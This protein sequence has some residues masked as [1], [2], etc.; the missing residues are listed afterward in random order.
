MAAG[1][2]VHIPFCKRKCKYCDFTSGVGSEN[3]MRKYQRALIKEIQE[4]VFISSLAQQ[5]ADTLFFGGGTPSIY[6][7]EAM[8]ELMT[9]LKPLLQEGAEITMEANPG[10]LFTEHLHAYKAMGINRLSIGL[11]SASNQ[12]LELLGRIHDW[13]TFRESYDMARTAGFDNINIDLISAV[14]GQTLASFSDTMKK[15]VALQPEHLS[16]YSLI[17]EPDT[18]FYELYGE[19]KTMEHLLPTEET[20]R[21]IYH[22]T[23][24][25]L[26]EHGYLQYEI[27]NYAKAGKQSRHNLKYWQMKDYYG[28]GV[29]AASKIGNRR[30]TNT[31]QLNQYLRLLHPDV[32]LDIEAMHQEE[33]ELSR[34]AQMEEYMFLGLRITE[35]VSDEGFQKR[36]GCSYTDVYRDVIEKFV[37][38]GLLEYN[39]LRKMLKL[40][41]QGLDVANYVMCE[42]LLSV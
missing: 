7:I 2:Y 11:Q 25:Y 35:G 42:F 8:W 37:A 39:E 15:V 19:G 12:E 22:Y 9:V 24:E 41:K 26:A 23:G 32:R 31:D 40:T 27:S 18:P 21:A 13:K 30:Y 33:I 28:F 3:E 10:T 5:K 1:I 16:V 4:T 34:E 20:D 14:P 38:D 29:S 6:P 17:V 36:F